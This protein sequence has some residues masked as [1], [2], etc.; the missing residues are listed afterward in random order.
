MPATDHPTG[1]LGVGQRVTVEVERVAHGGHCVARYVPEEGQPGT[2]EQGSRPA[3][4]EG[5][6]ASPQGGG[7]V[8]FVRYALPGERVLAVVTSLGPQERYVFADSLE[9]L[10]PATGRRVAPCPVYRPGGCGGCDWLHVS[11]ARS[12]QLKTE[13]VREAFTRFG[14]GDPGVD[15][16]EVA[17]EPVV[18]DDQG[19]R[20]RAN[21]AVDATGHAGL[22]RHHSR[23]VIPLGTCP[24]LLDPFAAG[25]F[26][27]LWPAGDQVRFVAAGAVRAAWEISVAKGQVIRERVGGREFQVAGDGF[28]QAHVG[29]PATLVNEVLRLVVPAARGPIVDLYAGVGLFGLSLLDATGVPVTLV[30]GERR[31]AGFARRNAAGAAEVAAAPVE[32]WVRRPAPAGV[33]AVVLDPPRAGA[34]RVVLG[35]VAALKPDLICYVACDPV[36]L[37]RDAATLARLGYRLSGLRAFDLFPNTQHIE[38]VAAFA[39]S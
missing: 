3:D 15:L 26:G 23:E 29:A 28:W 35:R 37:A 8:V 18:P 30:E 16:A 17:V 31:A 5:N 27:R 33:A 38:A 22:R 34:G 2:T 13:V 4:A 36:A 21:L 14:P 20:T 10:R 32:K 12:R 9:V 6:L 25:A 39:Q 11:P 24:Q 7:Q 19:W 1:T